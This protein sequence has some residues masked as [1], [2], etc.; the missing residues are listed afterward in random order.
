MLTRDGTDLRFV[1]LL[2]DIIKLCKSYGEYRIV[3]FSALLRNTI[4]TP[5]STDN[6]NTVFVAH[7]MT[8]TTMS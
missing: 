7:Y 2:S 4:I 1:S 8:N 5:L 6:I 3:I